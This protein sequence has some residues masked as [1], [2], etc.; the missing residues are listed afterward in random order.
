MICCHNNAPFTCLTIVFWDVFSQ[1]RIEIY[2]P[3]TISRLITFS[4]LAF[5][6]NTHKSKLLFK[7]LEALGSLPFYVLLNYIE[8]PYI[9][10][11]YFVGL[12]L[13]TLVIFRYV[14]FPLLLSHI[15][16]PV[17]WMHKGRKLLLDGY[18]WN[19]TPQ[20]G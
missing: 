4:L 2:H 5:A 3:T 18:Q 6:Y 20:N 1:V 17:F 11:F 10:F 13:L 14:L 12:L 7:V 9:F 15:I 8:A 19:A 16:C